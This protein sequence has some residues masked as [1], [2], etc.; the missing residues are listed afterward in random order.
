[1]VGL[2]CIVVHVSQAK[3]DEDGYAAVNLAWLQ[4]VAPPADELALPVR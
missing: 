3:S 1:M 2:R 4:F